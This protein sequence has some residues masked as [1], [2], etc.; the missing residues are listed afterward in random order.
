MDT[1][2]AFIILKK[3]NLLLKEQIVTLNKEVTKWQTDNNAL[4]EEVTIL[5]KV[6]A[7]S[8]AIANYDK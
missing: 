7:D 8:A 3:E 5:Y 4:M 6:I 2:E 1:I